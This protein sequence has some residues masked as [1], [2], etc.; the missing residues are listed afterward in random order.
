M[1]RSPSAYAVYTLVWI[2]LIV[3]AWFALPY[4]PVVL[5]R[6]WRLFTALNLASFTLFGI[7]KI[8][9]QAHGRRVPEYTLYLA[10]LA[11]GSIGALAAMQLFRHKT[12]KVGFQVVMA[13]L[14]LIHVLLFLRWQH[15]F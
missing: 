15:L 10:T 12:R 8:Q 7:D 6:G 2:A 13:I 3:L 11:G 14:I 9:A 4:V 5:S 1:S